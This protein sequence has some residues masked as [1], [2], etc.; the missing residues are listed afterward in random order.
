MQLGVRSSMS[1]SL[2]ERLAILH[3]HAHGSSHCDGL[4][5]CAQV[6][7]W[8]DHQGK[9]VGELSF[10]SQVMHAARLAR[11]AWARACC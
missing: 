6:M 7:M 5:G 2:H 11:S 10:R 3:A 9:C 8:D 1:T 4:H